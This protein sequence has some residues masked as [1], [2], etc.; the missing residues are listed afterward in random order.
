MNIIGLGQCG[1]NIAEKFE[2]YP[3]YKTFYINT[4]ESGSKNFFL[5]DKQESHQEYE[6][7]CPDLSDFLKNIK[8][9]VL[10]CLGGS[11]SISG[12]SLRVLETIR[13]QDITILFV[14]PDV[15]LLS[16]TAYLQNRAVFFILQEY[17]RSGVFNKIVLIENNV[18]ESMIE[19]LTILDRYDKINQ[20]IVSTN[21][22]INVYNNQKPVMTTSDKPSEINRLCTMGMF[23]IE[24][25][26]E[27]LFFSL[28]NVSEKCYYYAIPEKQLK[29]DTQ[30]LKKITSQI[31]E[32]KKENVKL[33]Y[34]VYS[35][36]Y[37]IPYGYVYARSSEIQKK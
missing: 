10:F 19:D 17:A 5:L 18:V 24:T 20:Y 34:S 37:D 22:M 29:T 36:A 15:E 8:G 13:E 7:N 16:E 12:A 35:T 23:D 3:Q 31:K 1:C 25:G 33:S 26:E 21:H 30:L 28:D 11:G 14:L 27:N 2:Q 32:K 4:E 6:A 9:E